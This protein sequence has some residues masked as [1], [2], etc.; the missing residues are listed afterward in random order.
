MLFS[1]QAF[2]APKKSAP[3]ATPVNV[4]IDGEFFPGVSSYKITDKTKFFSIREIAEIYNA[5]LEWKPISS[6]VTM[7]INNRKI[8]IKA[9]SNAVVFGKES[10][11]MSMPSRLIKNELYIPPEIL[12][13]KDFADIADMETAWN[14]QTSILDIAHRSNISAIR[15]FTKPDSTQIVIH[16]TEPLSYTISKA[17]G[18]VILDI[19]R[20]Q[21]QRDFIYANNGAVRDITYDTDGKSAIVKINLQQK[22][23]LVKSTRLQNPDRISI[24]IN[25][26]KEV[27]ISVL[28][29]KTIP[30][31]EEDYASLPDDIKETL[32][33]PPEQYGEAEI[34]EAV[35]PIEMGEDN[36][37]LKKVPVV[38]FQDNTII[39]DSYSIIDDTV[40]LADVSQ[41]AQ[42]EKKKP[43][44]R[45]KIIVV[46]A[47]HGGEDPGA[48]GPNGTKEKDINLS[49][50]HELKK[51]LDDD[52]DFEVVLTRKDDS[53]IPLVERTNIANEHN[54]D[55]FISIHCN[56][57]FNRS[58]SGFE[59][60][61]LSEKATDSEAA[62]TATLENSVIELEG[63]PTKK[64]ALLQEMLWSMMLNEYIND[65]AELCSFIATETPGRLKIPN[66]GVKQ[67]SFYVLRGAQMP[68][69]LIESAF[70][71]N[72]SEESKLKTKKFQSAVADSVYE[73]IKKYYARKDKQQN[74][75]K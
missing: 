69:V 2:A 63:K 13:S 73:G 51:V 43:F 30:E 42:P 32:Q 24:D 52:E 72:Y 71:S 56:A 36:K 62:A 31:T 29:E 39:D 18:A 6:M 67:A 27:D 41:K 48:V 53:F 74:G 49:I 1:L 8:D 19:H 64:R 75:K 22:P 37:D 47:G 33:S 9:D 3:E 28:S 25:H 23:K 55:L 66:R 21:I 15:Y 34:T 44:K 61:F 46:D 26:S 7:R 59:V 17:S 5:S 45:K 50:A 68:S 54:A 58:A 4:I 12:T 16:L 35:A 14:P 11:K 40:T 20:G 38:K 65:S 70:L 60:Y 57:N 10:K